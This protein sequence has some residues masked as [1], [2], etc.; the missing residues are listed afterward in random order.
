MIVKFKEKRTEGVG[1]EVLNTYKDMTV[2]MKSED[3]PFPKDLKNLLDFNGIYSR[4]G[5]GYLDL[6]HYKNYKE[7]SEYYKFC[8]ENI[9]QEIREFKI[10][11]IIR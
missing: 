8:T 2:L 10:K 7:P 3:I 9:E 5:V 6:E 4:E 11:K 1:I